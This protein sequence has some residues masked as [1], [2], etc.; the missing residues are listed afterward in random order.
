M[1]RLTLTLTIL[2]GLA[3][4]SSVTG[5]AQG[6]D[7]NVTLT[8]VNAFSLYD[9]IDAA[10]Q[11]FT[12]NEP[13]YNVNF[14]DGIPVEQIDTA[15]MSGDG[16]YDIITLDYSDFYPL[17]SKG[18]LVDLGES[19]LIME[20]LRNSW[21]QG[22][23]N[24]VSLNDSIYGLP[25]LI[26]SEAMILDGQKYRSS[27]FEW[28]DGVQYSWSEL[29]DI[30]SQ[31]SLG[32]D[33]NPS[34]LADYI[35]YPW[36]MEQYVSTQNAE[37]GHV[38][39][40][41]SAFRVSMES[42]KKMINEGAIIDRETFPDG[43][44]SIAM[45]STWDIA[46]S[47]DV[48]RRMP[49]TLEGQDALLGLPYVIVVNRNSKNVDAAMKL[50]EYFVTPD[51]QRNAYSFG[52]LSMMLRDPSIEMSDAD[53]QAMYTEDDYKYRDILYSGWVPS[54]TYPELFMYCYSG[55][56]EDYYNDIIGIDE[57]VQLVQ[58]KAAMIQSE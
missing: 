14:V 4:T 48:L 49:P 26:S 57:L 27:E 55:V 34:L 42:Y 39:F 15:L 56:M 36:I 17:A 37:K 2:L 46:Q 38:D 43:G 3:M 9:P 44:S 31:H 54:I 12:M 47:G 50:M 10:V 40:D 5:F 8:I 22:A 13:G 16:E 18:A 33:G 25:L 6:T 7:S 21:I 52:L 51:V 28:P 24:L 19:E 11:M 1:K 58:M 53:G 23:Y 45:M 41:T 29:A 30:A 35:A 20:P 32:S